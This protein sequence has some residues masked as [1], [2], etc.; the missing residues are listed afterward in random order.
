MN[1][2][3]TTHDLD[4][5]CGMQIILLHCADRVTQVIEEHYGKQYYASQDYQ[6]L[7]K[8]YGRVY[9]N[10]IVKST[11]SKIIRGEEKMQ[12]GN[13][14]KEG[15]RFRKILERLTDTALVSIPDGVKPSEAMDSLLNDTNFFC[16]ILAMLSNIRSQTGDI[17][18]LPDIDIRI[19]SVLKNTFPTSKNVS[20]KVLEK[21]TMH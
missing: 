3:L 7:C 6:R 2:E 8:Q 4:I 16:R 17:K 12:I 21:F 11:V 10:E 18:V 5:L 9:A 14:L 13:L 15:E 1:S 19:E 20:D